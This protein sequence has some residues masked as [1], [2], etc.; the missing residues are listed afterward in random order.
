[1]PRAVNASV[2]HILQQQML[3]ILDIIERVLP[4]NPD[5]AEHD[6]FEELSHAR[7]TIIEAEHSGLCCL[8][9]DTKYWKFSG[10]IPSAHV[11]P[12]SKRW[13]VRRMTQHGSVWSE[14]IDTRTHPP[15][16]TLQLPPGMRLW[17]DT[18][19]IRRN[20]ILTKHDLRQLF[21]DVLTEK[22]PSIPHVN[23][24]EGYGGGITLMVNPKRVMAF[25]DGMRMLRSN[26]PYLH[27][28]C[29]EYAKI[30]A[31]L[32]G[33]TPQQFYTLSCMSITRRLGGTPISLQA[34]EAGLYDSGPWGSVQIGVA[35]ISHDFSPSLMPHTHTAAHTDQENTPVRVCVAEGVLTVIDGHARTCYSHGY[36]H[37]TS[38]HGCGAQNYY[39]IDFYMDSLQETTFIG[40]VPY[41]QDFIAYT[42][43]VSRHVVERTRDTGAHLEGVPKFGD[44]P[45]IL[46][47][48]GH[49][50]TRMRIAESYRLSQK[51]VDLT[52][53][54]ST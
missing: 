14:S 39:T 9:I 51:P 44:M 3:S 53:N 23:D 50:R 2:S 11:C 15:A 8:P 16:T 22:C 24:I 17:H 54:P 34:N 18:E 43:V 6:H 46:R 31:Y 29:M 35:H 13:F 48:T 27:R 10:S 26:Y 30:L 49:I 40:R 12:T 4:S 1:M 32:Y 37:D 41:I 21:S 47:L 42:P 20:L 52:A 45:S 38:K 36:T 5:E 19:W 25:R 33:L 28:T 7:H